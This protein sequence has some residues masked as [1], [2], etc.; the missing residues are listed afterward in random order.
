MSECYCCRRYIT[1]VVPGVMPA[2]AQVDL[3]LRIVQIKR[4]LTM[5]G[6]VRILPGIFFFQLHTAALEI[7]HPQR[8]PKDRC[9]NI[10]ID[11]K[12]RAPVSLFIGKIILSRFR[13]PGKIDQSHLFAAVRIPRQHIGISHQHRSSFSAPMLC[14]VQGKFPAA[15]DRSVFYSAAHISY[16]IYVNHLF[17]LLPSSR[18]HLSG[19]PRPLRYI[20]VSYHKNLSKS[21]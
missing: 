15:A 11:R 10:F 4:L 2:A 20:T 19:L 7:K 6:F 17:R 9:I 14:F 16:L 18:Y 3:P 5:A 21:I 1:S 12:L 13:D 8:I